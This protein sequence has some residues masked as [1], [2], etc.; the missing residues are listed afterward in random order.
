MW[1]WCSWSKYHLCGVDYW[2]LLGTHFKLR[3]SFSVVIYFDEL[4]SDLAHEL[5]W[6]V[7]SRQV[8]CH[9]ATFIL[10]SN[11]P[12]NDFSVSH[13]FI[14]FFIWTNSFVILLQNL[15]CL[16]NIHGHYFV[17]LLMLQTPF[18]TTAC[19]DIM[20][21]LEQTMDQWSLLN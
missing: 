12:N 4:S 8:Y 11:I 17:Y 9:G 13:P 19:T 15:T 18:A 7:L 5:K 1:G 21:H 10:F 3:S 20:C 2:S 14:Y 16:E 6:S